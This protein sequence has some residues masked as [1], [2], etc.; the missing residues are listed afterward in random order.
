MRGAAAILD[1]IGII[2]ASRS[3]LLFVM[4][5][6]TPKSSLAVRVLV[7]EDDPDDRDLLMH[8]LRKSKI[9]AMVKFIEDG[10]KAF[11][12]LA[13]LPPAE[14]FYDLIA[15]FLDLKLPSMN[16]L[17]LLRRIKRTPR[18]QGIPV[19]IMT[20]S[21]DPRD[22]EECHRLKVAAYISKP[23][24]FESFAKAITG[25]HQLTS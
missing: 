11:D 1:L 16:G 14:P 7:I 18:L 12:F 23:V 8:Q 3:C 20:A 6:F 13:N 4:K 17:E 21:L 15:I 25:L 19:I 24:T 10:K 5:M 22:F 9:D 2:T